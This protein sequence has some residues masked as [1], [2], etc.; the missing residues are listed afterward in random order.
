MLFSFLTGKLPW[1]INEELRSELN[2]TQIL[3]KKMKTDF[4]KTY[5]K[6]HIP[7]EFYEF[8]THSR[9][10]PFNQE[11]EYDYYIKR[12]QEFSKQK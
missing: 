8:L 4:R 11:P 5:K 6:Y 12:F 7:E 2:S 9:E 10:L 1:D 3:L